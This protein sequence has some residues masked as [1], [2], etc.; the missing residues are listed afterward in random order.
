MK[1]T[2][3]AGNDS[4]VDTGMV[5]ALEADKEAAFFKWMRKQ[6]TY[7]GELLTAENKEGIE[8][9]TDGADLQHKRDILNCLRQAYAVARPEAIKS[10]SHSSYQP[11]AKAE[12]EQLKHMLMDM[13]SWGSVRTVPVCGVSSS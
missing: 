13:V 12:D 11:V 4:A 3:N 6:K 5:K 8:A 2:Y 9:A 10:L 7:Y 1:S